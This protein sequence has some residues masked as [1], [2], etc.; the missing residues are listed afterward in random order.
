MGGRNGRGA[1]Q[2]VYIVSFAI[3]SPAASRLLEVYVVG[4][5]VFSSD[6]SAGGR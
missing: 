5:E 2:E 1:M 3:L 6:G 4:T